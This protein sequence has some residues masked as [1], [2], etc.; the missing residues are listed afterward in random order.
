MCFEKLLLNLFPNT[1]FQF[2]NSSLSLI[3][4][5]LKTAAVSSKSANSLKQMNKILKTPKSLD[6]HKKPTLHDLPQFCMVPWYKGVQQIKISS[7]PYSHY[8]DTKF[9]F[10]LK[11]LFLYLSWNRPARNH[12]RQWSDREN[13]FFQSSMYEQVI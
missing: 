13:V 3:Y 11:K 4:R 2:F 7:L 1:V 12:F 9:F 8:L 10:V 5:N 6:E